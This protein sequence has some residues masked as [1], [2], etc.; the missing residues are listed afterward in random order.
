MVLVGSVPGDNAEEVLRLCSCEIGHC[1]T[2]LSDGET[3]NRHQWIQFL[4][5]HTFHGHESLETIQRPKSADGEDKWHNE[6]YGEKGWL[7]KVGDG[8]A[9]IHFSSLGYGAAAKESYAKL[10]SFNLKVLSPKVSDSK[11]PCL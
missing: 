2:S 8:I 7:F 3:G 1:V 6:A 4:A 11:Y 5:A 9:D 10:P